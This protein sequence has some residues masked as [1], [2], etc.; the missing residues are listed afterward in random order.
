MTEVQSA[1]VWFANLVA[2]DIGT[3]AVAL[4]VLAGL[5]ELIVKVR[6]WIQR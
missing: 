5:I 6:E 4:T 1:L 3:I 2:S